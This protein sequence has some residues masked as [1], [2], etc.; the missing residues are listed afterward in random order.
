MKMDLLEAFGLSNKMIGILKRKYGDEL[1]PIQERAVR[2]DGFFAGENFLILAPTSAGKTLIG[3]M[4]AL[5]KVDQKK[6]V[7]Y[8]VPTKALAKEKF[9]ELKEDFSEVGIKTAISTHDRK[10]FDSHLKVCF[11]RGSSTTRSSIEVLKER[12]GGLA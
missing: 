9:E 6:R 5:T 7:I 2:S 3:E 12:K 8:L 10:E 1:L 4:L 11:L